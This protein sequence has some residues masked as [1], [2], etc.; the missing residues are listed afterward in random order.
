MTTM[1][2]CTVYLCMYIFMAIL[3]YLFAININHPDAEH[4]HIHIHPC[5]T[6]PHLI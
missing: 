1:F 4:K 3:N 6:F 5:M 2:S